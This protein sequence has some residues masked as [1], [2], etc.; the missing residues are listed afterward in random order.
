MEKGEERGMGWRRGCFPLVFFLLFLPPPAE[1]AQAKVARMEI[2][3]RSIF[4]GGMPFGQV[5]PYKKNPWQAPL[6]R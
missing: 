2:T 4:A 1:T 6:C 5:G 3:E